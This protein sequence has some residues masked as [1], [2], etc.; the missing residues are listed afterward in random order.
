METI[1]R[2]T[3]SAAYPSAVVSREK[4]DSARTKSFVP[5]KRVVS[6]TTHSARRSR[7]SILLRGRWQWKS[8]IDVADRIS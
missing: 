8:R 3:K 2:L 5:L 4:T 6:S 7:S 1:R